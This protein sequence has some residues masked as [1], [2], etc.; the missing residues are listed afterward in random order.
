MKFFLF[1][2]ESDVGD[3]L[4]PSVPRLLQCRVRG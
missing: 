4:P 3:W 2:A 1:G